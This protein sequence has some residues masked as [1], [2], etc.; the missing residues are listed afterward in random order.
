MG[1]KGYGTAHVACY[2]MVS[3]FIA[4]RQPLVLLLCG[5]PWTGGQGPA[6]FLYLHL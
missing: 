4:A 3:A 5:A 6:L 1:A 2:R